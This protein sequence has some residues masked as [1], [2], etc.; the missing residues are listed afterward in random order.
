MFS[1]S[2]RIVPSLA[3]FPTIVREKVKNDSWPVDLFVKFDI[4]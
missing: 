2:T 1:V 3:R 4:I